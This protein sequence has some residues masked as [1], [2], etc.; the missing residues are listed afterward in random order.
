M[1]HENPYVPH[2]LP[3]NVKDTER[4]KKHFTVGIDV[5]VFRLEL[6]AGSKAT[7]FL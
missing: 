4:M 1:L 5:F 6:F 2:A 7:K 3:S